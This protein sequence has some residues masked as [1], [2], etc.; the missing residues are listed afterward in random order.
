MMTAESVATGQRSHVEEELLSAEEVARVLGVGQVTV[1]RWCREGSLPCMK[2]GRSWRLRRSA[3]E[4]FLRRSERS[5]TL[6]GQLRS[7]VQVPDNIMAIVQ[8]R[9]LM[10]RLD[11]AFLRVGEARGGTLVKYQRDDPRLPSTDELREELR[12]AGMEVDRLEDARRLRFVTEVGEPGNRMEEMRRLV[13]GEAGNDRSIWINFNWDLSTGIEEALAQQRA[14]TELVEDSGLVIQTTVL[15]DDLDE[16][17]GAT[18]RQAHVMH[19]GTV[20]LSEAGLALSRV[21]PPP[22]L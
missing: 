5:S 22:A 2:I 20:W 17:P 13:A 16:W 15:E 7:F 19:S 21:V 18:Q 8:G 10:S 6:V 3:L 14:L 9:E 11:F 1:W 4:E 12:R